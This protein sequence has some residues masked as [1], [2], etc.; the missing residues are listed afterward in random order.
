[1]ISM[2]LA[3]NLNGTIGD[4]GR[5]TWNAPNDM[6]W[7]NRHI[8]YNLLVAGR[9]TYNGLP[10]RVKAQTTQLTQ[11]G[12]TIEQVLASELDVMVIGGAEIYN[13]F[14]PYADLLYLSIIPQIFYGDTI[15]SLNWNEWNV[16]YSE[17]YDDALCMTLERIVQK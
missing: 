8:S 9:K 1:M 16:V 3:M 15:F 11:K 12:N 6:R 14:L 17:G 7:F 5:L 13:Q 2:I 10:E 4:K